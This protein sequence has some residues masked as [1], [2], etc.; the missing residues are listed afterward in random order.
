MAHG[1]ES[2]GRTGTRMPSRLPTL[3]GMRFVAAAMVFLFH[4]FWSN[5]FAS[6]G[7]QHDFFSLFFQGGWTGVGFFFLLSGLSSRSCC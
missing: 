6:P 4:V 1:V 7:A 2:P 5:V 3:T